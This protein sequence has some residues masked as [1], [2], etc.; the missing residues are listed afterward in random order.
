MSIVGD[1]KNQIYATFSS[2]V[3]S[4]DLGAVLMDDFKD[5]MLSRDIPAFPC[6]IITSP[7]IESSSAETNVDNLRTHTFE[8]MVVEKGENI[9]DPTDIEDLMELI[10]NAFDNDPTLGGKA[11][12]G[13]DPAVSPTVSITSGDKAYI[14][15]VITL[16]PKALYTRS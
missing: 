5:D 16:K 3:T 9:T 1:I 14:L 12:A 10:V 2:L 6:A 13:L 4:G 7:A 8:I 11:N 15:F